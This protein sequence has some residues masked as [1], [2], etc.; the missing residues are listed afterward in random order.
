MSAIF[1]IYAM[2]LLSSTVLSYVVNPLL[3]S[4][5]LEKNVL[6]IR[7][8]AAR[9]SLDKIQSSFVKVPT[10]ISTEPVEVRLYLSYKMCVI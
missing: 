5:G 10:Y 6:E 3:R 4:R 7:E 1:L 9:V 2:C 8:E